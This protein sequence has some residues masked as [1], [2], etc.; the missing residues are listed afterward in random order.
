MKKLIFMTLCIL[1]VIG[2]TAFGTT[3]NYI[4]TGKVYNRFTGLFVG[5]ATVTFTVGIAPTEK[6]TV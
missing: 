6:S 1:L 3:Y 5:G 2:G 4:L